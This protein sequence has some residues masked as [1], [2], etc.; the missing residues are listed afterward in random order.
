MGRSGEKVPGQEGWAAPP[1]VP[2]AWGGKSQR[3]PPGQADT[4]PR[5]GRASCTLRP[6]RGSPERSL[7][8]RRCFSAGILAFG[9]RGAGC[10]RPWPAPPTRRSHTPPEPL[11]LAPAP[12][13]PSA[14]V[15]VL[16][17][18]LACAGGRPACGPEAVGPAPDALSK[19]S[20]PEVRW[21]PWACDPSG[22]RGRPRKGPPL[23]L[24]PVVPQSRLAPG[25]TGYAVSLV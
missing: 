21:V 18:G 2:G 19:Y 25:A 1:P 16:G 4:H 22:H 9:P 24:T 10:C 11:A 20:L 13:I 12:H 17:P 23:G 6:G 7:V 5:P 3:P 15:G 14:W 8:A